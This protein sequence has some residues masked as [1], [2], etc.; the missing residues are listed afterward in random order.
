MEISDEIK[1]KLKLPPVSQIA[2]IVRD[3]DKAIAY[4]EDVLGFGPFLKPEVK[5]TDKR[6]YGKPVEYTVNL[7]FCSLGPIEMELMQPGTG[8]SIYH[9]FLKEKGEGLHHLA[10][11]IEDM[12]DRL[13]SYQKMGIEVMQSGRTEIGRFA[14]LDTESI[15]GVIIELLQRKGRRA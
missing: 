6:Y 11:D 15:G 7:S 9:D 12:E 13:D 14:Y 10:F 3:M 2:V 8:Q 5:I 1:Q 4:Y